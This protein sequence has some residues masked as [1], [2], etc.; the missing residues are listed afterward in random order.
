MVLAHHRLLV[1][2]IP[3]FLTLL[4]LFREGIHQRIVFLPR[5]PRLARGLLVFVEVRFQREGLLAVRTTEVLVCRVGLHVSAQVRS[6]REGLATVGAAVWF[7][8][9]MGSQVT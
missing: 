4:H 8:P 9:R 3:V 5:T 7:L 2:G 1:P 6:I